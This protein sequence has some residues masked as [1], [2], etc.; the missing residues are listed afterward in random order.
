MRLNTLSPAEGEKTLRKRV[1]RGI[2]SGFGK[3]CGRGH[4]GQKSRSGG[5][6]K[7]GFEGGQMPLQ[8]RL[9]KVGFSSRVSIITDEVTLGELSKLSEDIITVDVLKE[10]NLVT[11]NIKRVKVIL[12]GEITRAITLDGVRATKGALAAI[13]SAGGKVN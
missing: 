11:K 7:V 10:H 5:F 1:G 12:S 6:S 13:E 9:P 3:T 8:R 2:G 4:K